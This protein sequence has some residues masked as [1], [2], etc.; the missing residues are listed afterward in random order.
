MGSIWGNLLKLSIFGESHGP[1][2]GIVLEGF[3][4]GVTLEPEAPAAFLARRA[5]G[6]AAHST[7]RQESDLPRIFSGVKDG[8]STGAPIALIIENQNTRSGDYDAL[9]SIPRPGHADY[10]G[11]VR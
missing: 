5:P 8:V 4:A 11:A 7:P 2:I 3:P 9:R 6:R 10:T 1:G